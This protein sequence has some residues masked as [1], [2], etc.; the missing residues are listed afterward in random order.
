MTNIVKTEKYDTKIS[1]VVKLWTLA[2]D[3]NDPVKNYLMMIIFLK[4]PVDDEYCDDHRAKKYDDDNL[5]SD[6]TVD[7]DDPVLWL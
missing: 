7:D 1:R 4:L 3:N 5:K 6:K 2:V